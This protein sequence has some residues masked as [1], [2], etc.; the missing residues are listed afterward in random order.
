MQVFQHILIRLT[1]T[2]EPVQIKWTGSGVTNSSCV[3]VTTVVMHDNNRKLYSVFIKN[4]D[5]Y[6]PTLLW[7]IAMLYVCRRRTD[8]SMGLS[9]THSVIKSTSAF[10]EFACSV[11]ICAS[12]TRLVIFFSAVVFIFFHI[13]P[14]GCNLTPGRPKDS[15]MTMPS[16]WFVFHPA[17]V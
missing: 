15:W 7:N 11:C 17:T 1:W 4:P 2:L 5:Q 14:H 16:W 9:V 10:S 12:S 3:I 13:T 6:C 8:V